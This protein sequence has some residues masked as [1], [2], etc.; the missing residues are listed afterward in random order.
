MKNITILLITIMLS[1]NIVNSEVVC[2]EDELVK[3]LLEDLADNGKLD[4]LRQSLPPPGGE[5]NDE[6]QLRL[7]ANWDSDCSFEADTESI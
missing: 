2:S 1:L 6:K 4:C 7:A 5:S 3:E